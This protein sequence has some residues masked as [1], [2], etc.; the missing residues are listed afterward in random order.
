[1]PSEPN[2]REGK[3]CFVQTCWSA[4]VQAVLPPTAS[5]LLKSCK[6]KSRPRALRRKSTSSAPAALACARWAPLWWSIPRAPST[7][8]SPWRTCRK[9]SP[10][11]CSRAVLSSACCTRRLWWTT[12][13]PSPSMRPPS[14]PSRCVSPCA[15][16]ASSTPR[17]ST[18][19]LPRMAMPPSARSSPR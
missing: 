5:R 12:T 1:M 15:T 4:E 3:Q 18:S 6:K 16:A 19:T 2:K 11:T 13:P 7:A 8:A 17:T 14:T 9:S 10:S